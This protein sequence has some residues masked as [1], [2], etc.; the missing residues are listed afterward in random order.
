MKRYVLTYFVVLFVLLAID[1]IWL[2]S[3]SRGLYKKYIGYLMK[4]RPDFKAA[5]FFYL[6]YV[7]GIVFLALKPALASSSLQT[8]FL[9]CAL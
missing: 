8:A 5:L 9:S 7:F 3:L 1:A 2:G 4:E 6:I